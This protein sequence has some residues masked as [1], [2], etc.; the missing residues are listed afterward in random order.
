MDALIDSLPFSIGYIGR[1]ERLVTAN[2]VAEEWFAE[3]RE[4]MR[5]R[6][7]EDIVSPRRYAL[8][9]P[10]VERV[11]SGEATTFQT[12]VDLAD[13]VVIDA[14]STYT[15]DFGPDHEVRGFFFMGVDVTTRRR[16]E[17]ELL[18][19]QQVLEVI[20]REQQ[21]I[22]RDLHDTVG[23]ELTGL[24]FMSKKLAQK[25]EARGLME[26]ESAQT[27]ADGIKRAISKVRKAIK[28]VMP[29]EVDV[30]GLMIALEH[31]SMETRERYQLDCHFECSR[32][33]EVA[34]RKIATH[35]F[36][37]AQE[38]VNNAVKH[39]EA[40]RIVITLESDAREV[41]LSIVNDGLTIEEDADAETSGIGVR[42]MHFRAG[43]IGARLT[44]EPVDSGG[45]RVICSLPRE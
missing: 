29:V 38:A 8:I 14:Q 39:G 25:L 43:V 10:H 42:I 41:L 36:R 5:G 9:R 40:T 30:K 18:R 22:S 35:L 44:M 12:T 6:T 28:G 23:Q 7:I 20:T 4:A 1:D 21:R 19:S 17:E 33:V 31:L 13:G 45:T 34:D 15:P 32:P 2:R 27:I 37:I 16:V 26:A 11:L 24:S 3:S